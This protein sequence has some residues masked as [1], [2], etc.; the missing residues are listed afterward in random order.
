MGTVADPF[1][2]P[3][4]TADELEEI[5]QGV[6]ALAE[7]QA[8]LPTAAQG[9]AN[10]ATA[11][12]IAAAGVISLRPAIEH[13]E[14]QLRIG[15]ENADRILELVHITG[16]RRSRLIGM[17][18]TAYAEVVYKR[19]GSEGAARELFEQSVKL[20]VWPADLQRMLDECGTATT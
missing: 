13:Q 19:S 5:E 3:G 17:W 4:V 1:H 7:A 15:K 6:L 8:A 2:G 10:F 18:D 9:M 11:L 14:L 16:W 12:G 20:Q